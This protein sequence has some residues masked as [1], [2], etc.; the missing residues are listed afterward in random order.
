[1]TR[2]VLDP[3]SHVPSDIHI[4]RRAIVM[5][6]PSRSPNGLHRRI[7]IDAIAPAHLLCGLNRRVQIH[8]AVGIAMHP[9]YVDTRIWWHAVGALT[10]FGNFKGMEHQVGPLDGSKRGIDPD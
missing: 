1:M 3:L 8:T 5:A 9:I 4:D 2:R 10:P 7:D 6:R